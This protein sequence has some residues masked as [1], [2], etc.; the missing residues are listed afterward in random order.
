MKKKSYERRL[1]LWALGYTASVLVGGLSASANLHTYPITYFLYLFPG[2]A[3]AA[4]LAVQR[5]N[6]L[7]SEQENFII[8]EAEQEPPSVSGLSAREQLRTS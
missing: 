4:Y 2:L 1:S 7:V 3:V 5:E 6:A 8:H